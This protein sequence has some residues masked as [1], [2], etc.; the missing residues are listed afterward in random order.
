MMTWKVEY[1][2]I[3]KESGYVAWQKLESEGIVSGSSYVRW[4]IVETEGIVSE[5][6]YVSYAN[7][8]D[9]KTDFDFWKERNNGKQMS[10]V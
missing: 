5:S 4:Q 6:R 10:H 7:T 3:V 2:G 1:Q 9:N 8:I